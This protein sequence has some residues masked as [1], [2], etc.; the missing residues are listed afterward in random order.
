M[1][2]TQA[3]R[4]CAVLAAVTVAVGATIRAASF[5]PG[6]Q[7]GLLPESL[8]EI[9]GLAN[10]RAEPDIF[11]MH[12]DSGDLPRVF[13][14]TRAG[15]LA[16]TYTLLGAV[17]VDWEAMAIGPAPGGRSYLYLADIGDNVGNRSS[18]RVY[19]VM[20]PPVTPNQAPVR[21]T[22]SGVVAFDLVY[23]D[24]PRDAEAFM[25]DPLTGDFFIISKRELDGNRLYRSPPPQEGR[26]SVLSRVGTFGFTMTTDA[27]ISADGLQVIVRRYSNSEVNPFTPPGLAASYWSRPDGS[28]SLVD[29]LAQ[30][31]QVLPLVNEVQGEAIAFAADG[32][33]FYTTT[34]HGSP[35]YP[36]IRRSPLTYYRRMD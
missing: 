14:V 11:W 30:P 36:T 6:V 15:R 19:R 26:T 18:I 28:T 4:G 3:L 9:S 33:G 1:P 13:A 10:S 12:N 8:A 25:I 21:L 2:G 29:L 5:A 20:E 17:A 27:D 7:V 31:G 22:L 32:R 35:P 23:E 34:E 24:G 16:G